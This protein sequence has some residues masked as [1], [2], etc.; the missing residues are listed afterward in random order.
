MD[1]DLVDKHGHE[2]A[3]LSVGKSCIRFRKLEMLPL[4]TVK[5]ILIETLRQKRSV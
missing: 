4:D 3:G 5:V 1:T 2:L